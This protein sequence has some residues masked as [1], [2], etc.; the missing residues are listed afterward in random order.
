[1]SAGGIPFEKGSLKGKLV[2]E[3]PGRAALSEVFKIRPDIEQ[4]LQEV[5]AKGWMHFYVDHEANIIGEVEFNGT[6]YQIV[7]WSVLRGPYGMF[8]DIGENFP[9]LKGL[10][11]K[12]LVYNVYGR[13][14]YPRAVT[15]DVQNKVITYVND[16][17]WKWEE[18][19][20]KDEKKTVAALETCEILKWF[21]GKGFSLHESYDPERYN[22]LVEKF[23]ELA[24]SRTSATHV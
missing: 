22:A 24:K 23:T 5:E 9:E 21:A 3:C 8:I 10:E 18:G 1:M 11:L 6:E 12:K 13:N 17:F 19:W 14:T 20:E 2:L 16:A 4:L 7:P 15:V